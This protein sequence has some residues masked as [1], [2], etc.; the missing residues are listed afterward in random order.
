MSVLPYK[1]LGP[2]TSRGNDWLA[3][4]LSYQ[5]YRASLVANHYTD[6]VYIARCNSLNLSKDLPHK[7]N[8]VAN[9]VVDN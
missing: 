9:K 7:I 1:E 8:V 5:S 3:V 2:L 4:F 6:V